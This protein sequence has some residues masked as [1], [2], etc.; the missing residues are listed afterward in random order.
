VTSLVCGYN[1]TG[2]STMVSVEKN[3]VDCEYKVFSRCLINVGDGAQRF[4]KENRI[5]LTSIS[6]IIISSLTP[7][8]VSGFPGIFLSLSDMV[9]VGLNDLI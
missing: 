5:K 1:G 4:C 2:I 6:C 7:H 8:N 9:T 3:T